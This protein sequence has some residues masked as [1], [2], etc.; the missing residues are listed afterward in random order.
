MA[1]GPPSES[2]E[3]AIN[4]P[5]VVERLRDDLIDAIL[6]GDGSPVWNE[7]TAEAQPVVADAVVATF[8]F[9]STGGASADST[10]SSGCDNHLRRFRAVMS[11]NVWLWT[12]ESETHWCWDG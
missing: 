7:L 2:E 3:I 4:D 9:S 11:D 10:N 8:T 12:Y 6:A 5:E 1:E